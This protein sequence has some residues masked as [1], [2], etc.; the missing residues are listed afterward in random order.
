ML[1]R[2][3]MLNQPSFCFYPLK[4]YVGTNELDDERDAC[5]YSGIAIVG[6]SRIFLRTRLSGRFSTCFSHTA[7]F[8]VS[9][10]SRPGVGDVRRVFSA[11]RVGR[12]SGEPFTLD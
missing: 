9:G 5:N 2:F 3:L 7:I 8:S 1:I 6:N 4:N 11:I 10:H 12:V